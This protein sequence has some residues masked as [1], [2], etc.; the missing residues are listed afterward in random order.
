MAKLTKFQRSQRAHA[1]LAR[2][3]PSLSMVGYHQTCYSRQAHIK[4]VLTRAE[5]KKIFD[6]IFG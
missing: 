1:R 5:R 6:N 3:H 4:R 2:S